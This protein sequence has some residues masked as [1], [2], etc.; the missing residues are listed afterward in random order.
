M[1]GGAV[2]EIGQ[3]NSFAR[4]GK[5]VISKAIGLQKNH[6]EVILDA[7]DKL[8]EVKSG[9]Y[10]CPY[11]QEKQEK[12]ALGLSDADAPCKECSQA[13][14]EHSYS[15]VYVNEKNRY[16]YQPTLKSYAI[17][18]LL[19][20]HFLQPDPMGLVKSVRIK[21]LSE[22]LGCTVQ[23]IHNCNSVLVEY[24]YCYICNTGWD[25]GCINVWLAE[26][27]N[28]HLTANE[29]GRGYFTM[30]SSMF[31]DILSINTLNP[32]RLTLKGL[33][34]VDN[35][36]NLD[37]DANVKISYKKL[38]YFLPHYCYR[39]RIQKALE[40]NNPV[41]SISLDNDYVTYKLPSKL[42]PKC[43]HKEMENQGIEDIKDYVNNLND[44]FN[45]YPHNIDYTI[46]DFHAILRT[47]S[48]DPADTY[49]PIIIS[50]DAYHD[51]GSMCAQYST[52][53]VRW[54]IANI[55]NNFINKGQVVHNIG[56][57]VR[58][59]IRNMSIFKSAS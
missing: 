48:I 32:L 1:K 19:L 37:T 15:V 50:V 51:L 56:A 46:N 4:I 24:G 39:N 41:F 18:L 45:S 40:Q 55:Y 44:L 34:E 33:L 12:I 10:F 29:G 58:T 43:L 54:A 5:G 42:T 6:K 21:D 31:W 49:Q 36:S 35:H 57:L 13:V 8:D 23:T 53:L 52:S 38:R 11:Y 17:K 59:T 25:D 14:W 3:L 22:T 20:Y 28:Y 2:L 30:P 9:C 27:K 16:G 47:L 7:P 26:Y